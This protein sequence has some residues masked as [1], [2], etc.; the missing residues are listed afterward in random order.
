MLISNS[1]S[2]TLQQNHQHQQKNISYPRHFSLGKADPKS[3]SFDPDCT[4]R[5]RY[6]S[7]REP[8]QILRAAFHEGLRVSPK[9]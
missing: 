8:R 6:L 5:T 3:V 7:I 4:D 1:P 2:P 9:N